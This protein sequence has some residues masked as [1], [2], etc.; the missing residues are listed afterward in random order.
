MDRDN[1]AERTGEVLSG[2]CRCAAVTGRKPDRGDP[3][4]ITV[5]DVI[6]E[7]HVIGKY[8]GASDGDAFLCANFRADRVRQISALWCCRN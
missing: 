1:R 2:D 3:L 4:P 8:D 6:T 7:P 5:G